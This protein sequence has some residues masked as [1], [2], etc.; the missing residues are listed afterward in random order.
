MSHLR[1]GDNTG[2]WIFTGSPSRVLRLSLRVQR[3]NIREPDLTGAELPIAGYL[4]FNDFRDYDILP[5]GEQFVMV[6]PADRTEA[7][8]TRPFLNEIHIVFNWFTELFERVP[9][10]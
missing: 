4:T 6:F 8:T 7:T 9:V 5:D 2:T 1:L 3:V 10:D